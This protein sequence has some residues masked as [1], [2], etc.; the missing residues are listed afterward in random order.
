MTQYCWARLKDQESR[1]QRERAAHL[2][3]VPVSDH[4][5][6]IC[7]RKIDGHAWVAQEAGDMTRRCGPCEEAERTYLSGGQIVKP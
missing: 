5:M 2:I 1:A 6:T 4:R 7:S 3:M